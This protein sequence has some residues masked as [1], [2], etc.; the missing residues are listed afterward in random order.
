MLERSFPSFRALA[1]ELRDDAQATFEHHWRNPLSWRVSAP[2]KSGVSLVPKYL[3]RGE[4]D[5]FPSTLPNGGRVRK[6]KR[7]DKAQLKLLDELTELAA[8]VT[9]WRIDDRLRSMGFA[10]HYGFPTY[11]VDFT[12][13][14]G[15]ALHFAAMTADEPGPSKRVV[16]RL[17]LEA[18]VPKLYPGGGAT[19]GDAFAL[20]TLGFTR[21]ERQRAW[22]LCSQR[23]G[24]RFDLQRARFLRRH[25]AKYTIDAVDASDCLKPEL[26]SM[27]DDP[28][29]AWPLALLRALKIVAGGGL[30]RELAEWVVDRVP[31][32]EWTPVDVLFDH[33]GRART[34]RYHS[35]AQAAAETGRNYWADRDAVL[36]ELV[37]PE[38]STPNA[39]VFGQVVGGAP[40]HWERLSPGSSCQVKWFGLLPGQLSLSPQLVTLQ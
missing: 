9:N 23:R 34:Y 32:Y 20:D 15:V 21:P 13:E 16:F 10:Q 8:Q 25:L 2:G 17:D 26:L 28:F 35:P 39:I 3:Y 6:E 18:A 7:F 37:S 14:L 27:D 11:F 38:I 19:P 22:V 29:A 30:P 33:K 4:P 31:L 36:D 24:V 1:D 40:G 5:R 12:S